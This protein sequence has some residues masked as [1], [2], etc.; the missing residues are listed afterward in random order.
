MRISRATPPSISDSVSASIHESVDD[1]PLAL[2]R[3]GDLS[4]C[5]ATARRAPSSGRPFT[6]TSTFIAA[7]SSRARCAQSESGGRVQLSG[8]A[9]STDCTR[10]RCR[11]HRPQ[12]GRYGR[13]LFHPLI[14]ARAVPPFCSSS[15][16]TYVVSNSA[17]ANAGD[18]IRSRQNPIVVLMPRTS[19]SVQC[20]N[21]PR[22]WLPADPAPMR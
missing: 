17:D 13:H 16:S 7:T 9:S 12:G 19:Y 10:P 14:A 2:D 22:E 1:T 20:A 15:R 8:G 11:N 21:H 4:G 3:D 6:V 5:S 18:R